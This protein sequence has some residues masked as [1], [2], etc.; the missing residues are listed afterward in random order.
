[1]TVVLR[2]ARDEDAPAVAALWASAWHDGHDGHVPDELVTLRTPETFHARAARMMQRSTVATADGE[3][4]GFVTVTE[5]EV[6]QVFVAAASRGSGTASLL[7]AEAERQVAAAGHETAWLAVVAGN[8]RARRFYERSGWSDGGPFSYTADGS[9]T[10]PCLRYV[11]RLK[12]MTPDDLVRAAIDVAEEG[13]AQG[14]MPIGAV[15]ETGGRIIARAFTR[16]V[17]LGRRLVHADL[18]AMIEAD[19]LLGWGPRPHP[20]RL[21]VNLE[22]CLMCLGA[23]MALK[24]T[25]VYYGLESPADG[26]SAVAANWPVS[27]ELPWYRPPAITGGIHRAEARDQFRRYRDSAPDSAFRTWAATLAALPDPS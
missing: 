18:L 2:P 16:D 26:G 23:A 3:I 15:V 11:K 1:M 4:T 19:E 10:V 27:P 20:V 24:V 6:E 7:L 8:A 9:I 13:M 5:D 17:S 21:A 12:P 14:E 25:D 22:P